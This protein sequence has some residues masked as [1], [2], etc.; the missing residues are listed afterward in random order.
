MADFDLD[1]PVWLKGLLTII[2][3]HGV[4]ALLLTF[5]VWFISQRIVIQLEQIQRD[6]I[7]HQEETYT[8]KSKMEKFVVDYTE[9]QKTMIFLQ[10]QT[11]FNAAGNN[12]ENQR[13]CM[14]GHR[15]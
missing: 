10:R 2:L 6:I 14:N 12:R 7:N 9:F 5:L 8:A 11:C 1:I 15:P 13:P 3:Q 4:A